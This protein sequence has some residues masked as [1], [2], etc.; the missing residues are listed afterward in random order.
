MRKEG[1]E[2]ADWLAGGG[3][4]DRG[5]RHGAQG[6]VGAEKVDASQRRGPLGGAWLS[7]ACLG[8]RC[9][10]SLLSLGLEARKNT[11]RS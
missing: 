3:L 10:P 11:C 7:R 9:S 4:S 8:T 1:P 6:R 5:A 2:S